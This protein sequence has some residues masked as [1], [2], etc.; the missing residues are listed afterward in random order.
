M[1]TRTHVPYKGN[2]ISTHH[3][4]SIFSWWYTG[5]LEINCGNSRFTQMARTRASTTSV[6][7]HLQLQRAHESAALTPQRAPPTTGWS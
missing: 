1:R 5:F 7:G 2:K 6:L 3:L 4:T